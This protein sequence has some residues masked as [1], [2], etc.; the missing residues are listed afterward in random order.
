MSLS[1]MLA[2]SLF[3]LFGQPWAKDR[4]NRD[5]IVFFADD[6]LIPL[7][8]FLQV[9]QKP[10]AHGS[11]DE[12]AYY[13]Y[14]EFLELGVMLLEIY[15]RKSLEAILNLDPEIKTIDECFVAASEVYHSRK[16]DISQPGLRQAIQS[17]LSLAVGAGFCGEGNEEPDNETLRS[18]LFETVVQPLERDLE[19]AFEGLIS[20]KSLDEE[21]SKKIFLPFPIPKLDITDWSRSGQPKAA[22]LLVHHDCR[23]RTREPSPNLT[24][25]LIHPRPSPSPAR[26]QKFTLFNIDAKAADP[27]PAGYLNFS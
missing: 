5:N 3:Y 15:F 18:S 8:P 26:P 7:R 11:P 1:V 10:P 12:Q 13:R 4:W 20:T 22:T 14:P 9:S 23:P 17:C 24:S 6:D 19:G 2:Y 25:R 27:S 21:A 16:L